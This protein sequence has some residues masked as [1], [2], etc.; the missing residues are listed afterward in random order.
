[1]ERANIIDYIF[2]WGNKT[3]R[4]SN[5][6]KRRRYNNRNQENDLSEASAKTRSEL[7]GG[8]STTNGG[9]GSILLSGI[10]TESEYVRTVNT[11]T[12]IND[13]TLKVADVIDNDSE[14][15]EGSNY[16]MEYSDF[17][18]DDEDIPNLHEEE[19]DR[20]FMSKN[21]KWEYW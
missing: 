7:C 4:R 9:T 14:I 2:N 15:N 12:H 11:N 19:E 1:M 6:N 5:N 20:N 8:V 13:K 18:E 16:D 10:L 3:R 21:W 17:V